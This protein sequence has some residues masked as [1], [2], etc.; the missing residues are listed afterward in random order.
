MTGADIGLGW[1]DK[2]GQMHFQVNNNSAPL[3]SVNIV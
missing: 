1:I 3:F 2:S